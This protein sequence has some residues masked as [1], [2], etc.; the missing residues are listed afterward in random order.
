MENEK[1]IKIEITKDLISFLE[2]V[3]DYTNSSYEETLKSEITLKVEKEIK[4]FLFDE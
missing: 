4:K 1:T 2:E 3:S